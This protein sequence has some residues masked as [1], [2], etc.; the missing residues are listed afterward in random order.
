MKKL[1]LS[2]LLTVAVLLL[3]S[4]HKD[5]VF[6]WITPEAEVVLPTVTV[7]PEVIP[8][9]EVG[10]ILPDPTPV[11]PCD[12]I[13]GNISANGRKLYHAPGMA[14][15]NQVKI[16]ESKGEMFFCSEQEA[17]DSGW[18]RANN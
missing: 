14:N 3:S 11:P 5:T 9:E 17:V 13:K 16:D 12:I 10:E 18:T 6:H 1:I 4:C 2:L 8:E 7:E 15:Y